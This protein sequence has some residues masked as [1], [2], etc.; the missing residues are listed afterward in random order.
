MGPN[1]TYKT[2]TA[3][4]T[5]NKKTT[6]KLKKISANNTTDKGLISKMLSLKKWQYQKYQLDIKTQTAQSKNGQK[7]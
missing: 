4:K 2:C 5:I 6:Y 1:Q 3:K 7:T